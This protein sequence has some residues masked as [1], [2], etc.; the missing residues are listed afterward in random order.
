MVKIGSLEE[1]REMGDGSLPIAFNVKTGNR[2]REFLPNE[3]I[4]KIGGGFVVEGH[5]STPYEPAVLISE[6]EVVLLPR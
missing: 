2:Y 4:F 1:L 5:F 6:Q 3:V